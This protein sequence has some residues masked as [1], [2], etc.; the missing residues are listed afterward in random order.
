MEADKFVALLLVLVSV[1]VFGA[2]GFSRDEED[3]E[4]WMM[5]NW[6]VKKKKK[7]QKSSMMTFLLS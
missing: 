3:G 4:V 1:Q 7:T 2:L 5:Q 6:K